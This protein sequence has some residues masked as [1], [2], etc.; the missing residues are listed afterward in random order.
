[1]AHT[2][3]TRGLT[4]RHFLTLTAA[5][6]AAVSAACGGA[7][8]SAP[9][10][11]PASGAPAS[12]S[13]AGIGKP[14]TVGSAAPVA[15]KPAASPAASGKPAASISAANTVV[16]GTGFSVTGLSRV[17]RQ[18]TETGHMINLGLI[19]RDT[20][21]Y[22]NL[23]GLAEQ[24]PTVDNGL[25]KI[26]NDGTM[27]T[28]WH[29]RP[30]LK[31]HDG[32]PFK[33]SAF[34]LGYN[35]YSNPKF[36]PE[37]SSPINDDVDHIET[38]DDRTVNIYWKRHQWLA[39]SL[40]D[41]YL[42]PMPEHILGDLYKAGNWDAINKHPYWNKEAMHLG[43]YKL[44]EFS[45]DQQIVFE[46]NPNYTLGKPKI[47]RIIF[48]YIPDSNAMLSAVLANE[49]DVTTRNALT[50]ETGLV[51]D[52]QWAQKGQGTVKF[53]SVNWSWLGPSATSPIFGWNAPNQNKIRQALLY[54][55]DRKEMMATISHGKET[56]APFPLSPAQPA[57]KMALDGG[58][59]QYDY[60]PK[61]AAQLLD[62][63]GWKVGPDGVR[64][65]GKGDRFSV[66]FRTTSGLKDLEDFQQAIAG[67]LKAVGIETKINNVTNK[68]RGDPQF[69]NHWPGLDLN[70]YNYQVEDWDSR[71]SN[72][73]LPT[74]QNQYS[75]QN[76]PQWT[77]PQKQNLLD[78]IHDAF[79]FNKRQQLEAD[80]LKLFT[81]QLPLL[82][83]RL[84]TELTS[85]R[86]TIKN[87]PVR[88]E[89]GG[90]NYRTWNVHLWEKTA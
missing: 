37:G 33:A 22:E 11:A 52:Q 50:I 18:D 42:F 77:D 73:N 8:V 40:F 82:P 32:T 63:S 59:V 16:I 66:D 67:Y 47:D 6:A 19:T 35:I 68:Q 87:V 75:G 55:I 23:P 62:D 14:A 17:G 27:L 3:L 5:A 43:P 71:Y 46:A 57:Y 39:N 1:M 86:N 85:Y 80:F 28:T 64:V 69:Q 72:A 79:D 88:L 4:R 76:Q 56:A 48:R 31:W 10:G 7:S 38:P 90:E 25:W 15:S 51:A 29:L 30:D 83:F 45:P 26:N 41:T 74:E 13:P 49:V 78:Q 24:I 65:N 9:S 60:D 34:T 89:T 81:Q 44:A 70:S 36:N 54:A 53:T 12:T 61:K 2:F 58:A 84:T 20:E 21:K